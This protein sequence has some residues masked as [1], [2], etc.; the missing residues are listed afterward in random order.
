[1]RS[2]FQLAVNR[3]VGCVHLAKAI[4]LF[5][6]RGRNTVDRILLHVYE[7]KRATLHQSH[8]AQTHRPSEAIELIRKK[9]K[10][11]AAR[12]HHALQLM[13]QEWHDLSPEQQSLRAQYEDGQL[14][15]EWVEARTQKQKYKPPPCTLMRTIVTTLCVDEEVLPTVLDNSTRAQSQTQ[16]NP[17]TTPSKKGN[18]AIQQI[19]TPNK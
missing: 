7:A 14:W 2:I 4:I 5:G 17:A 18:Y 1:M 15:N 6:A 11:A 19:Q 16:Q 13:T 9:A 3:D 8:I 12:Y 10:V